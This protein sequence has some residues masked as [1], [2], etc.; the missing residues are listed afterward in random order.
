[1]SVRDE[2][3]SAFLD[4]ELD[5]SECDLF[6]RRIAGDKALRSTALRYSLIGDAMR[7]E[8]ASPDPAAFASAV[9]KAV[10]SDTG[11]AEA[12]PAKGLGWMRTMVGA[13]VAAGV[14]VVAVLSLQQSGVEGTAA[15]A[16]KVPVVGTDAVG[17][18][19]SYTVPAAFSRRAG[20][21]DRLSKYYLRHSEYAATMGG[22]A[23]LARIV[24]AP[25]AD[26]KAGQDEPDEGLEEN[27][28]EAQ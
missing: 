13:A 21:P 16:V 27:K 3:L 14:A 10:A 1:M 23:S 6:V 28:S 8:I 18:G 20:S 7:D 17:S 22:Q 12:A 15:P 2:Q 25:L 9:G 11:V 19:V 5:S 24:S 4:G 26:E